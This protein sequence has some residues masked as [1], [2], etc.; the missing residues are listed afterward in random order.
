M[1]VRPGP[2]SPRIGRLTR[3]GEPLRAALE[4]GRAAVNLLLTAAT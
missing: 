3:R 2:G 4:A 1:S